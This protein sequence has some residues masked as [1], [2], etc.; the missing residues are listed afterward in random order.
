MP[1]PQDIY[2]ALLRGI[3]VGGHSTVKMADLKDCFESLGYGKVRTYINSG[4]VVFAVANTDPRKLE[5]TIEDALEQR[6][7]FRIM[8]V[9]R[10]LEEV[11]TLAGHVPKAWS[12]P[13]ELKRNVM[14]LH[15]SADPAAV[16]RQA[17][18]QDIGEEVHYYPGV[19]FWSAPTSNVGKSNMLKLIGTPLYKAMTIRTLSTVYK[20]LD[21][22]R[23][24]K[25]G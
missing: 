12:K 3:N 1:R 18:R 6:F 11:E 17:A 20:L 9:V 4:N 22:M 21:L 5:R 24:A 15:H 25:V 23:A 7:G 13:G 8:V 14:F 2:L 10:N 19:L 16:K